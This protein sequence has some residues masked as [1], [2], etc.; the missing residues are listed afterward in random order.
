VHAHVLVI[1]G[2]ILIAIQLIASSIVLPLLSARKSRRVAG[3][4]G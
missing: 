2:V 4:R 3:R 1:A